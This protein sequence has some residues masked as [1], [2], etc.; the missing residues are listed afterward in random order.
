MTA[1]LTAKQTVTLEITLDVGKPLPLDLFPHD[2]A[3]IDR[4][5]VPP[6]AEIGR[7]ECMDWYDDYT[8]PAEADALRDLDAIA[9]EIATAQP[10]IDT[11][12][13]SAS[14]AR[15]MARVFISTGQVLWH[16]DDS[17]YHCVPYLAPGLREARETDAVGELHYLYSDEAVNK[18]S[19]LAADSKCGLIV[20][21]QR[22][23]LI[24]Y[25]ADHVVTSIDTITT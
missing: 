21:M 17:E 23:L 14:E 24:A 8:I 20:D 18:A 1:A 10:Q 9:L 4:I 5:H 16:E 19:E 6:T 13:Y 2:P 25:D 15:D 7:K 22:G 3:Q 12:I 11:P